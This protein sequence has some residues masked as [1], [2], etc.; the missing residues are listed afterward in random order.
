[1]KGTEE[2]S[3]EAKERKMVRESTG[4]RILLL[5]VWLLV[6]DCSCLCVCLWSCA[7]TQEALRKAIPRYAKID[8]RPPFTYASLIRQVCKDCGWKV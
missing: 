3:V 4:T 7:E 8:Q 1:M 5:I 2:E 6:A